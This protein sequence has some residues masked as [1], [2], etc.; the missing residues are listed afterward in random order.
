MPGPT[1]P[2]PMADAAPLPR[3]AGLT[4]DQID[5]LKAYWID[6]IQDFLALA[7]VP[8]GRGHL[9]T[10][11]GVS[12][13]ALDRFLKLGER[14]LGEMRGGEGDDVMAVDYDAGA[15]APPPA[16]RGDAFDAIAFGGELPASVNYADILPPARNQ[17]RRGTCVAHAA[18]AVRE[19]LEIQAGV[20]AA[21][22]IDLSEQFIYWWCKEQDRLPAVSGTY[23]SLGIECLVTIGA[24]T[25]QVWP[26]DA[27]QRPNDEGHG[28]PPVEALADAAR[29]RLKRAYRLNPTDVAGLK[30][31][32][33]AGKALLFTIP[34]F[35]SWYA[36]RNTRRFGKI[37]MPLPG[38]QGN[39]AHAMALIGY[40]DDEDA[41]GGGYFLLRNSWSPWGMENPL[42]PG[43]GTIPYAFIAS[44]NMAAH[45]GDRAAFSDVY[46]RT[47]ADDT[48]EIPREGLGYNSPDIWVRLAADG[49]EDHQM[50][51]AGTECWIYVRA[52][53][54][55]P[56]EAQAV[57]AAVFCAPAS[58]SIW[59]DD[60]QEIGQVEFPPIPAGDAAVAVLAWTPP[61]DGPTSFLARL[62][63]P[64]DPVQHAW[65]P[66]ADNNIAQKNLIVLA[67]QPGAKAEFTFPMHGL[68][69]KVT[70]MD[71]AV[72]R[73][74]F[75]RGRVELRMTERTGY[76]GGEMLVEDEGQLAELAAQATDVEV[77]GVAISPD[78][79]AE[80]GEVSEIIFTQHY[81]RLLVGRLVVRVEIV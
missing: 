44:H 3:I 19:M 31:A 8:G 7:E 33:A 30:Q 54:Q 4:R 40:V 23:P 47:H 58:P 14:E 20:V 17:G 12:D 21:D 62:S 65:S 45:T 2:R 22:E 67:V 9:C 42:A 74:A 56:G 13:E 61:A 10:L 41:P 27:K 16:E 64:E 26:Y 53:N 15:L 34:I 66:R 80:V 36:N 38:E 79:S 43:Y 59:P 69:G 46:L 35:P 48:G 52:W 5:S 57:Q 50:P 18:A 72:D 71:L 24:A 78:A 6:S 39:G 60:W 75:R 1:P 51:Q 70:L 81:G 68:P 63:S 11:L 76:R 77:V 55:G 28:P 49:A 37:I 32:L 73:R 29:Y 25:E